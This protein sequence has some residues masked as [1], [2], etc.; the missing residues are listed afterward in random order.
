M[1]IRKNSVNEIKNNNCSL[2]FKD[3]IKNFVS[4]NLVGNV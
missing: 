1:N 3:F 2:E 4:E